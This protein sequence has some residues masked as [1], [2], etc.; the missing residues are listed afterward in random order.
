MLMTIRSTAL[1]FAVLATTLTTNAEEWSRFR[2]PN[3]SGISVGAGFPVTFGA[4]ENLQWKSAVRTGRSSPVLTDRHIFLTAFED[5]K[6]YTQCFDRHTGKLA[7]ERSLERPREEMIHALNEPASVTPVTDGENVYVFFRDL[8]LVSYDARGNTRW[9]SPLGPFHNSEGASASPIITGGQLILLVDQR[10]DGYIAAFDLNDGEMRWKTA[11]NALGGWATPLLHK[12][13]QGA[14]QIV[15]AA[16]G[17]FAG[18]NP[19]NGV[20]TWERPGLSPAVVAS[21]I[22]NGKVVYSFGY[23]YES[24]MLYGEALGQWDEDGDGVLSGD[25]VAGSSWLYQTDKYKGNND[26]TVSKQEWD[27]AFAQIVAPSSVVALDLE[28]DA[29]NGAASTPGPRQVWRYEKNFVGVVPS[30]LLY[31]GILYIQKNGGILTALDAK[32][33]K[34][35]KMGR[36][37]EALGSY[38]ASPVAADGKIYVV[39]D[40]GKVSVLRAGPDWEVLAVNELNEECYAT[41]ALSD[42]KVFVRSDNSLF[43]FGESPTVASVRTTQD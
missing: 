16:A 34:V 32:T 20:Q 19:A 22:L 37:R 31:E 9:T 8:G 17:K 5:G 12:P 21:P 33:G 3:G 7:W 15:T 18:Y 13:A 24:P 29:A 4:E 40:E 26:G 2:G 1:A 23:G 41:P 36:I 27:D 30:P 35:A 6:L 11:R 43:C 38:Y 39:S 25:E 42:G 10:V 14:T 28:P